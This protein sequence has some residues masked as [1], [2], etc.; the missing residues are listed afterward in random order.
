MAR[1]NHI[2]IFGEIGSDVTLRS[3]SAQVDKGAEEIVVHINSNGGSVSEGFAI[4]DYLKGLRKQITT[5]IDGVSYSIA[6]VIGLAGTIRLMQP[7]AKWMIH[8]P[9]VSEVSGDASFLERIAS[10]L[11][12]EET[13]MV[14]FYANNLKLDE[15]QVS[16][17]M[18]NETYFDYNKAIE[19][20]FATGLADELKAVAKLKPNQFN[21]TQE[22][23][24]K[25]QSL[26][27]QF[28]ALFHKT[29]GIKAMLPI[30]LEDGKTVFVDTADGEVEGKSAFMDE[31]MTTPAPDGVHKLRDGRTITVAGGKIVTVAVAAA[32]SPSPELSAM[33]QEND[34]M[35][36][37]LETMKAAM[38]K[39]DS[40]IQAKTNDF[41][42]LKETVVKLQ[43]TI[44]GEGDSNKTAPKAT[45]KVEV[46]GRKYSADAVAL[47]KNF[48]AKIQNKN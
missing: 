15:S 28:F 16:Q 11:K 39:K 32:P 25:A 21:M 13:R 44:L 48:G 5:I 31:A 7:N 20:G 17:L 45:E 19:V 29:S 1:Q 9:W 41:M 42:A 4:H 12:E 47:M 3:V 14:K 36:A 43:K 10:G 34:K 2:F 27:G 26:F 18:S 22:E 46:N 33:K 40:E 38:A 30:E 23:K 6:S 8:N 24:A 35:K 37:E